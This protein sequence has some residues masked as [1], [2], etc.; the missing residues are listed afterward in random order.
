[1]YIYNGDKVD[2]IENIWMTFIMDKDRDRE[3]E[4]EKIKTVRFLFKTV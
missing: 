3:R 1:M 2:Q 4:R